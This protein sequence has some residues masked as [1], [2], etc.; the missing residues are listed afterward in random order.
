M[1]ILV[2]SPS[3]ATGGIADR[4][5]TRSA[6]QT[7]GA[8]SE[9]MIY[10]CFYN[11]LYLYVKLFRTKSSVSNFQKPK[12]CIDSGG[13][14]H[15]CDRIIPLLGG[16]ADILRPGNIGGNIHV[17]APACPCRF[18]LGPKFQRTDLAGLGETTGAAGAPLAQTGPDYRRHFSRSMRT[19][20]LC[21][22][23]QSQ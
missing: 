21:A 19:Y 6:A 17:K 5:Q 14:N 23:T 20:S 2:K 9:F 22:P 8:F 4:L 10:S 11:K 18:G 3:C 15:L 1:S 12:F 7:N 16:E 13:I